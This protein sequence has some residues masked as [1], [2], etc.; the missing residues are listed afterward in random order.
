MTR[1]LQIQVKRAFKKV[2]V[3]HCSAA[4]CQPPVAKLPSKFKYN[5][6]NLSIKNPPTGGSP[7][8]GTSLTQALGGNVF[9]YK[10]PRHYRHTSH[11]QTESPILTVGAGTTISSQN[12]FQASVELCQ[13]QV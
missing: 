1:L 8:E 7:Q 4:S 10:V 9:S 5:T 13:E 11:L 12:L 6:G 3:L 2:L